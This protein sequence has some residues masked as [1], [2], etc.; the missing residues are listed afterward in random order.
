M[1]DPQPPNRDQEAIPKRSGDDMGDREPLAPTPEPEGEEQSA[2]LPEEETYE[3]R[4]SPLRRMSRVHH[5]CF[6]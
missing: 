4:P 6:S 5:S 2:P 3:Q 1:R